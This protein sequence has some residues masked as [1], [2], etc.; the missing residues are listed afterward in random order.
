M[1]IAIVK[2]AGAKMPKKEVLKR[3]FEK[4]PDGAGFAW[5]NGKA[6]EWRKG[7]M[8]FNEFW[9]ALQCWDFT[10][11]DTVFMHFRWGTSGKVKGAGAEG[12]THPF[13][14]SSK[15]DRLK[16]ARGRSGHIVMHNGVIGAGTKNLS[17]TMLY[18]KG[19]LFKRLPRLSIKSTLDK[20]SRETTGSRLAIGLPG[21]RIK[22]TGNWIE[23]EDGVM[24]SKPKPAP[25]VFKSPTYTSRPVST[26]SFFDVRCD[27]CE[28]DYCELDHDYCP[29]CGYSN[30]D[31]MFYN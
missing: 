15:D 4:N 31:F 22:F 11:A 7:L 19:R 28:H 8:T 18:V 21:G 25:V 27:A 14:V 26:A 9:E 16:A 30:N 3:C 29:V 23:D 12:F 24:Y 5:F 10:E 1:C 17:D 2:R 20:I 13:P 6:W